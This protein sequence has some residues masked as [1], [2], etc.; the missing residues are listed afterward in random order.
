MIKKKIFLETMRLRP[1]F[2]ME[3]NA[4]QARLIKQIAS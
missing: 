3:Q 1:D 2:L 4:L